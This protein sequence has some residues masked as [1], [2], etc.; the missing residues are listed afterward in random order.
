[1]AVIQQQQPVQ[2]PNANRQIDLGAIKRSLKESRRLASVYGNVDW[3]DPNAMVSGRVVQVH[4]ITL[5]ANALRQ[6]LAVHHQVQADSQES[7][8]EAQ[9][10][11]SLK[12]MVAS[13]KTGLNEMAARGHI[14]SDQYAEALAR[15][16]ASPNEYQFLPGEGGTW[17]K[18]NKGTG[19]IQPSEFKSPLYDPA[20]QIRLK[21]IAEALKGGNATDATGHEFYAPAAARNPF[22]QQYLE[23]QGYDHPTAMMPAPGQPKAMPQP[24]APVPQPGQGAGDVEI[25]PNAS[26]EDRALLEQIA[27][28]QGLGI[29]GQQPPQP[30]QGVALGQ[31]PAEEAAAKAQA[32][33]GAEQQ[34][35]AFKTDEAIRQ[36]AAQDENK[37]RLDLQIPDRK[38]I[39]P[40]HKMVY[41][42][43]NKSLKAIDDAIQE[44]MDNPGAFG[45]KNM[46]GDT[47]SQ[48]IDPKGVGA[49]AKVMGVSAI[50]RHDISGAAISATE[51]PN[52]QPFIPSTSDTP[53]AIV[54]KLEKMK[55]EFQTINDQIGQ[56]YS[57]AE[58]YGAL[59]TTAPTQGAKPALSDEELLK[60]YG[61]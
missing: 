29:S 13:G 42:E 51:S 21:G 32:T 25:S 20:Q 19:E 48:R 47:V 44:V 54:Q 3:G 28:Q 34:L 53:E 43:N 30:P 52:L 38:D 36:K 18:G 50:K 7:D 2:Q 4:P 22:Y 33:M 10:Q 1:M 57:P 46:L 61:G 6:G 58:G 12:D 45:V 9:T 5:L 8:L 17:L 40:T 24:P 16:A 37:K 26:P 11:Q 14:T 15:Q 27:R 60:K 23:Q 35:E 41:V 59:P 31:S 56:M 55:G 39:P 49:R